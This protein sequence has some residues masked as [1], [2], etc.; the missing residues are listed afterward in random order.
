M[1]AFDV[2]VCGGLSLDLMVAAPHLPSADE[3]TIGTDWGLRCG[4]RGGN[5][6][7][8][9]ARQGA[10]TAMIGRVGAD[11][12]GL[13]LTS[14]LAENG[15]DIAEV[16]SDADYRTGMSIAIVEYSGDYG[17]VHVSG[18]NLRL[19]AAFAEKAF[20]RM[21]GAKVL[22]LQNEI[23]DASSLA[24]AKAAKAIGAKV[25]Y[26][27]SPLRPADPELVA[28]TDALI[29]TRSEAG[30]LCGFAVTSIAAAERA[31]EDLAGRVAMV[32]LLMDEDG[33]LFAAK[34]V[35][36]LLGPAHS[37]A[38]NELADDV[39]IG[40]LAASLA[41]GVEAGDAARIAASA[42]AGI[43]ALPLADQDSAGT[44]EE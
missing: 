26:N 33:F 37:P 40:A 44:E 30:L 31:A 27:A 20:R 22:V 12:F 11:D 1:A 7:V 24:A 4:G 36:T 18:S 34:G 16:A 14:H 42:A 9:A 6:A 35:P 10:R 23:P 19:D 39:F 15:V 29:L 25:I 2:I 38:Q 5:Q 21:G 3:T 28:L 8:A 32:F 13:K 17:A 41:Q 43:K